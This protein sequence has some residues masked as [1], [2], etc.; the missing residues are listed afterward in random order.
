MR[1]LLSSFANRASAGRALAKELAKREWE[2]PVV[3]ALPRGGVP[4]AYEI[5]KRMRAPLDL[6]MVR[7]LGAPG[8]RELAIGAVVDGDNPQTVLDNDTIA[9][10]RPSED[11]IERAI[12]DALAEI[13]RRRSVYGI[14]GATPLE[15]RTA[16]VVDDGIATGSTV[17]A[18]LKAIRAM[19]PA[20]IVLA[21]PVAAADSLAAIAPSC[22][23]VICLSQPRPFTAVGTHYADFGQTSDEEVIALLAKA[24][25]I[26]AES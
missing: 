11:Y 8:H 14:G 24:R 3:L 26:A 5:A 4:V 7:K 20:K 22:D 6:V 1:G 17:K 2:A 25:A 21:V 12:E 23:E 13:R 10:V 19:Q 16:I 15:A 9:M 18:A